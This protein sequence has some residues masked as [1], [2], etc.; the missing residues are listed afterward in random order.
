M[1]SEFALEFRKKRRPLRAVS[2]GLDQ[3]VG[4]R[5]LGDMADAQCF[6]NVH[7]AIMRIRRARVGQ[8]RRARH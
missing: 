6:K 4:Q 3:V 1:R 8:A 7:R 2:L 5:A